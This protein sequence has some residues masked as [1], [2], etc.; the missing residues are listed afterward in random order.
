MTDDVMHRLIWL[1][2]NNPELYIQLQNY[3]CVSDGDIEQW[4]D[5][6]NVPK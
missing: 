3:R 4:L 5:D 6:N 1:E 2:A